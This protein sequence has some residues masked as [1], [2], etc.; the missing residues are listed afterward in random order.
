MTSNYV[1][2]DAE[3]SGLTRT[4]ENGIEAFVPAD[5]VNRDYAEF[6]S[7]GATAADYVAPPEPPEPTAAEKLAAAGLNVDELKAL[8]AS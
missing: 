7:S 2:V 8:L 6:L 3:R 5:P 1:W 4:D